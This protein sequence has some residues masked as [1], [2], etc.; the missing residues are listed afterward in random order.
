M[1][2]RLRS[3]TITLEDFS[4]SGAGGQR[5]RYTQIKMRAHMCMFAYTH[6]WAT[7]VQMTP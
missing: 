1:F 4:W 2:L 5:Q 7:G 6:I 3:P